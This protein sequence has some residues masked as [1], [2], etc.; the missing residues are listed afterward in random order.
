MC[1]AGIE[2]T[3]DASEPAPIRLNTL[4]PN[5][6]AGAFTLEFENREAGAIEFTLLNSGGYALFQQVVEMGA[7]TCMRSFDCSGAASG[8][9]LLRLRSGE[10]TT[11]AR[12]LI[13]H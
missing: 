2:E 3:T 13:Q 4:Y 1:G 7:G 9:Y 6:N 10:K 5:P 8:W 11:F 12:V